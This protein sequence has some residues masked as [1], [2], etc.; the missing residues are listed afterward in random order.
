MD[1]SIEECLETADIEL[2]M[3]IR[4]RIMDASIECKTLPKI[5]ALHTTHYGGYDTL[6]LAYRAVFEYANTHNLITLTPIRE[7]YT[8]SPE[9]I[10]RGNSDNFITEILFSYEIDGKEHL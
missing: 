2:C 4:E 10:F 8:K 7:I 9:M 1:F 5:K 3:P 6:Y